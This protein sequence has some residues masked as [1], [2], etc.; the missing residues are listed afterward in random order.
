MIQSRTIGPATLYLGDALQVLQELQEPVDGLVTDPPYSSGG[1]VRGDRMQSP[2]SKYIQGG[3]AQ[4]AA[5]NVHF[6]GDN[7]DARSW[8]FWVSH[9]MTLALARVRPGGYAMVFTDWRQLPSLTDAFQAGGFVWRGLI[10]WDKTDSARAPHKG[11]FRHQCEYVVWGTNGPL[12]PATHGGPW[13]GMVRERVNPREKHHLTGK[14][15]G[16]MDSLVQAIQPGGLVLD[17]FMGSGSTGV[18]AIRRGQRFIGVEQSP[19]YFEVACNRVE[20]ELRATIAAT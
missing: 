2:V 6:S 4:Q 19:H 18:A 7:R 3:P 16:V 9:W 11:Y 5:H 8:A 20:H 14:P 15:I 1:L 13:P 17:P 10:P 12:S